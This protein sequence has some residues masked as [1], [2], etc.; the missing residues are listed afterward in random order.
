MNVPIRPELQEFIEKKIQSGAYV[1]AEDAVNSLIQY[2]RELDRLEAENIE[3][4]R[5]LVAVGAAEADR[6]EVSEWDDEEIWAEVE[7]RFAD[8]TKKAG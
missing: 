8:E 2:V 5:K 1:T 6:G 7:R 3:E 4:L